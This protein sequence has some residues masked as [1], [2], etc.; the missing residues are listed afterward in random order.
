MIFCIRIKLRMNIHQVLFFCFLSEATLGLNTQLIRTVTEGESVTHGCFATVNGSRKFFCKGECKKEEDI[1]V[2]TAA[3]RA[4][5]GRYSIEYTKGSAVEM[6]VNITQLKKSD[7][8]WYM[9]G[10]GRPSSPDSSYSFLIFV[11]YAVS[12]V[13]RPGYFWPL[14]VCV[15]VIVVL[16]AVVLLFVYKLKMKKTFSLNIRETSDSRNKELSV[17]YEN[18]PTGSMSEDHIYSA[19]KE[20]A[21]M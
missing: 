21:N 12:D 5:S 10:Y 16:V 9:C 19:L 4:Q 8:G 14:V 20:T 15:P 13:S 11:I 2:E 3:N 18:R 7:T 6:S 17:H 1:L